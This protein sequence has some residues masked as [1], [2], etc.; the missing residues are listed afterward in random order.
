MTS[1]RKREPDR[2][3]ER[4]PGGGLSAEVI[5]SGC[6]EAGDFEADLF[7]G[8]LFAGVADLVCEAVCNFD[9]VDGI[10]HGGDSSCGRHADGCK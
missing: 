10:V 6:K 5:I 7:V 4:R 8:G 3:G 1:A 2:R 9:G